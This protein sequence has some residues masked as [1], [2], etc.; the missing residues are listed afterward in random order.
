METYI[1]NGS[2][3]FNTLYDMGSRSFYEFPPAFG[4]GNYSRNNEA[5]GK[6]NF[7]EIKR[8]FDCFLY[9]GEAQSFNQVRELL[10]GTV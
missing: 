1:E 8:V 2:T 10:S 9:T 6:L 5:E 4:K 7:I 3:K